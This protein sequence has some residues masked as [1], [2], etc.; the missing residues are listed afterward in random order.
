MTLGWSTPRS[1]AG[2]AVSSST[3]GA[4]SRL[5]VSDSCLGGSTLCRRAGP[6][7]WH[8][9][10]HTTHPHTYPHPQTPPHTPTP[11]TYTPPPHTTHTPH[12]PHKPPHTPHNTHTQKNPPPQ[13]VGD[14][15]R[16][17]PCSHPLGPDRSVGDVW[18][19]PEP[20]PSPG[21]GDCGPVSADEGRDPETGETTTKTPYTHEGP[22][23][24][25]V[26]GHVLFPGVLFRCTHDTVSPV[27][28]RTVI[29]GF[30]A[31]D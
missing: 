12:T 21:T 25:S 30:P 2:T 22:R 1:P 9:Y 13:D 28:G 7:L 3:H 29:S 6:S 18:G 5:G 23:G 19:S 20:I 17:V 27:V 4:R 15:Y 16:T 8:T 31:K 14:P 10:T 24:S 26:S 11:H